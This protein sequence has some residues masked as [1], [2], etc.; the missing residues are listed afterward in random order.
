MY[1]EAS[2]ASQRS[3]EIRWGCVE[4]KL[5]SGVGRFR[6]DGRKNLCW[7][8]SEGKVNHEVRK[9]DYGCGCLDLG[10]S[11]CHCTD[12]TTLASSLD[13]P[14]RPGVYLNLSGCPRGARVLLLLMTTE[15]SPQTA[16]GA[17]VPFQKS[18]QVPTFSLS[19]SSCPALHSS[20]S[21][22]GG[23]HYSPPARPPAPSSLF[24]VVKLISPPRYL[25]LPMKLN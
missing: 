24:M 6:L 25:W 12:N 1:P 15:N 18:L 3:W 16:L 4:R 14:A 8:G 23:S 17:L 22:L 19:S 20:P 9:E 5:A 11:F 2:S 7:Q 13:S 10:K 21:S